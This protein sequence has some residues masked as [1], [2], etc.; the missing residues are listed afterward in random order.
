MAY[1]LFQSLGPATWKA[2]SLT[3]FSLGAWYVAGDDI[4]GTQLRLVINNQP[5]RFDKVKPTCL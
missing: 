1:R 3:E 4:R 5:A 2:L